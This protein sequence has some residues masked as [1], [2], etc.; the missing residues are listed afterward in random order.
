MK[1]NLAKALIVVTMFFFAG[2][3]LAELAAIGPNDKPIQVVLARKCV[4]N[5][6]M[7][8]FLAIKEKLKAGTTDGIT[9]N[10]HSIASLAVSMP[11]LYENTYAEVYPIEGSE[12]KYIG[13]SMSGYVQASQDTFSQAM[14]LAEFSQSNDIAATQAQ[15]DK[16]LASCKGCHA[17]YRSKI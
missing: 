13:G 14:A 9:L 17:T 12:F 15:A 10:A 7:A 2:S 1:K 8:N 3:A 6:M 11:P 5:V 16:L 4:K